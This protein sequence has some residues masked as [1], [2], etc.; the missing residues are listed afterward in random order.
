MTDGEKKEASGLFWKT[1]TEVRLETEPAFRGEGASQSLTVVMI[2]AVHGL[3]FLIFTAALL[4]EGHLVPGVAVGLF[5]VG[6]GGFGVL[7]TCSWSRVTLDEQGLRKR[8]W[9]AGVPVWRWRYSLERVLEFRTR[10]HTE[11]RVKRH[12][13][14]YAR[15]EVRPGV[16]RERLVRRT[17]GCRQW[18]ECAAA[19]MNAVLGRLK[20]KAGIG[21]V[22][23]ADA[24]MPKWDSV[25][26]PVDTRFTGACARPQSCRW[27]LEK[28]Q[29]GLRFWRKA[30]SW[31]GVIIC[32]AVAAVGGSL[33]IPMMAMVGEVERQG[34]DVAAGAL[35]VLAF[36]LMM[37]AVL[38]CMCALIC[39][40]ERFA[41]EHYL[42][43][44]RELE[45]RHYVLKGRG[46]S[47]AV[48]VADCATVEMY[49]CGV[50]RASV[51]PARGWRNRPRELK[52]KEWRLAF[53]DAH[54]KCL[55]E[56]TALMR[57]EA[58]WM[59]GEIL[60][61]F[62]GADMPVEETVA[63]EAADGESNK[64][65]PKK[66]ENP[67]EKLKFGPDWV[68]YDRKTV[69][70]GALL[71][72]LFFGGIL[73]LLPF[74]GEDDGCRLTQNIA[75]VAQTPLAEWNSGLVLM[76]APVV[77]AVLF[78]VVL[79]GAFLCMFLGMWRRRDTWRLD[80][81]GFRYTFRSV[82][83]RRRIAVPLA[84]VLRFRVETYEASTEWRQWLV[85]ETAAGRMPLAQDAYERLAADGPF[86][87]DFRRA[88]ETGNRVLAELKGLDV[89]AVTE[90]DETAED[91][92]EAARPEKSLWKMRHT[93][94]EA[95]FRWTQGVSWGGMVMPTLL[96]GIVALIAAFLW[97]MNDCGMLRNT[98][99]IGNARISP[100]GVMIGTA[101]L[102]GLITLWSAALYMMHFALCTLT[103]CV[104]A[105]RWELRK[106]RKML[107]W[108]WEDVWPRGRYVVVKIKNEG[109]EESP[110]W[111]TEHEMVLVMEPPS[112]A[113]TAEDADGDSQTLA[114]GLTL[115]EA[116]WMRAEILKMR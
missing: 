5:G 84:R 95:E 30:P 66:S 88:A 40:V 115:E 39:F 44:R 96:L 109:R 70:W 101:V 35:G 74:T 63:V 69:Q 67:L 108:R 43:T 71:A 50:K 75:S 86:S 59:R 102:G 29:G 53:Y 72:I 54:G 112:Y 21:S 78:F 4:W 23:E 77:M 73:A 7:A 25:F 9:V 16:V 94:K 110:A 12:E 64:K 18:M 47:E 93:E 60:R 79:L 57:D 6:L 116:R 41:K 20:E 103:D 113:L 52:K 36:P 56:M 33:G 8:M 28:E 76:V 27:E 82:F 105:D 99:K 11:S 58:V 32:V 42:I 91:A 49:E 89:T 90:D 26:T 46:Q 13:R 111:R 19:D 3:L 68:G 17:C 45:W 81:D 2:F 61:F 98:E 100:Q 106:V 22:R 1:E 97:L 15:V 14:L 31:M 55:G 38:G 87:E 51:G 10:L 92:R 65:P 104:T 34:N 114:G 24:E 62:Q 37:G 48:A 80:A 83:S 107:W 85:L